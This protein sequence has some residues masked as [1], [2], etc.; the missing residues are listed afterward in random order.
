MGDLGGLERLGLSD[1][2]FLVP[3]GRSAATSRGELIL[4]KW[5]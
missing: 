1:L 4:S 5:A 2:L 3:E